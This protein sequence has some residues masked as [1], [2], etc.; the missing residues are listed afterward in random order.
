LFV[1]QPLNAMKSPRRS[2]RPLFFLPALALALCAPAAQAA[3]V[4]YGG[5]GIYTPEFRGQANTTYFG[6][7]SGTWDGNPPLG[8]GQPDVT[9]D[10]LNGT[11]SINPGNLSGTSF[12]TQTGTSDIVSGSNN[13]YS[14]VGGINSQGLQVHVPTNGVV[15]S[16]G[17]TT[18]IIQGLSMSGAMFGGNFALDGF[19]FSINGTEAEYVHTVNSLGLGQWF[20]KFELTGNQSIYDIDI[21]G[22]EGIPGGSVLSVTDLQ[23]DTIYSP[24][25]FAPDSAVVPEPSGLLLSFVG[26][27]M[28]LRRPSRLIRVLPR[29]STP[30]ERPGGSGGASFSTGIA[31]VPGDAGPG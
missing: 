25:G 4:I 7:S 12:I 14:S 13:I 3:Y 31:V 5:T 10:I 18:I 22:V 19:G 16:E 15:G 28:L 23:V 20:A 27:A 1:G 2:R 11:P 24:T 6:W 21:F 17:F 30:R 9:P 26:A 29:Q 8:E